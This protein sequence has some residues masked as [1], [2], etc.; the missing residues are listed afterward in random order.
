MTKGVKKN[1]EK[2]N[3]K[4][5]ILLRELFNR[6]NNKK[7]TVLLAALVIVSSTHLK[8]AKVHTSEGSKLNNDLNRK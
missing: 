2:R 6:E 4:C 5:H 1:G 3:N 7:K 8:K